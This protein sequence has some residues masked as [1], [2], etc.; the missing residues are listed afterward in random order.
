ML[1][2]K[3]EERKSVQEIQK[4]GER[5]EKYGKISTVERPKAGLIPA[6]RARLAAHNL[7][8]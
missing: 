6:Y 5:Q 7:Q 4:I 8:A 1:K 3:A 2:C